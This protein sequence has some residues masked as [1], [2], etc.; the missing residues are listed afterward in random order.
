MRHGAKVREMTGSDSSLEGPALEPGQPVFEGLTWNV[1]NGI[2][3]YSPP[4]LVP[5]LVTTN[6]IAREA[7]QE[8]F[9]EGCWQEVCP[10]G[11]TG[12]TVGS[13]KTWPLPM[14]KWLIGSEFSPIG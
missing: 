3:L 6:Y 4:P 2:L 10:E 11:I 8:H 12:G 5:L 9:S 7:N 1:T 14:Q 13:S